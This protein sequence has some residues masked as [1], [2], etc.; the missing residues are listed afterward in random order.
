MTITRLRLP[1][2]FWAH[3]DSCGWEGKLVRNKL[4]RK[5]AFVAC[6]KCGHSVLAGKKP[7]EEDAQ[8]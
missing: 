6:P 8:D 1:R 3:C 4:P 5:D 7:P 2:K